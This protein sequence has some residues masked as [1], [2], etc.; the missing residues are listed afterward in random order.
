MLLIVDGPPIPHKRPKI[1]K[2]KMYDPQKKE[3]EAFAWLIKANLRKINYLSTLPIDYPV[4]VYFEFNMKM[5]D[6]LSLVKKKAL[7]GKNHKAKPDLSN[8]IKFVEDAL[9]GILWKDDSV[10]SSISA[11]KVYS[12]EPK[13]IINVKKVY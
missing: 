6:S 7:N 5:P 12:D 13:T 9:N 1:C 2:S 10:I 8:L 4:K 11:I 3:K